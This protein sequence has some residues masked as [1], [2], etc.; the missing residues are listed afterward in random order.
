MP[1]YVKKS[2]MRFKHVSNENPTHSFVPYEPPTYGAKMQYAPI[3]GS[4]ENLLG[5]EVK[6]LQKVAV[7]FLCCARS[8][9]NTMLVSTNDLTAAQKRHQCKIRS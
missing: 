1:H 8:M 3:E 6:L 2:F 9:D 7:V 5:A 4:D